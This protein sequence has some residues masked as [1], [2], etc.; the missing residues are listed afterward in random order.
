MIVCTGWPLSRP[1]RMIELT[2][3]ISPSLFVRSSSVFPDSWATDGRMLTGGTGTYCQMNISGRPSSGF[4]PKS[5]QSVAEMRRNK[6]HTLSGF[7]SSTAFFIC[8]SNSGFPCFAVSKD[9]SNSTLHGGVTFLFAVERLKES[10]FRCT[11]FRGCPLTFR[12]APLTAPQ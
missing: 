9:L 2:W 12:T 3:I 5:S 8:F 4:I 6:F 11:I 7:M 10:Y 1:A